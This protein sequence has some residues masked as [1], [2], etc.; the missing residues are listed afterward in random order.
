MYLHVNSVMFSIVSSYSLTAI[1]LYVCINYRLKKKLKIKIFYFSF[2]HLLQVDTA[3]FN[4]EFDKHI[5]GHE[6]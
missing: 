3:M 4:S 6:N 5:Q 2:I 1:L